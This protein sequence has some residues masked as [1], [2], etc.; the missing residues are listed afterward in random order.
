LRRWCIE[1]DLGSAVLKA[2][3]VLYPVLRKRLN[4]TFLSNEFPLLA[5][6]K[7]HVVDQFVRN[8]GKAHID[9]LLLTNLNYEWQGNSERGR[10]CFTARRRSVSA[11]MLFSA[12]PTRANIYSVK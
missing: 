1:S 5:L 10:E 8:G 9:Q 6:A 2:R 12:V 3:Q 11:M 7:F 4:Q